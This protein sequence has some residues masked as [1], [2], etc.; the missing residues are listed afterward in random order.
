M[1]SLNRTQIVS[2]ISSITVTIFIHH[3]HHLYTSLSPSLYISNSFNPTSIQ[4]EPSSRVEF[5]NGNL[6][7]TS[8]QYP[9]ALSRILLK[10]IDIIGDICSS[11]ANFF[12]RACAFCTIANTSAESV[13]KS[14]GHSSF[15]KLNKT[16]IAANNC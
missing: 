11:R 2:H 15:Q 16:S 7:S 14:S 1:L 3:C 8:S 9:R 13:G 6:L 5:T 10:Y 4:V 12:I